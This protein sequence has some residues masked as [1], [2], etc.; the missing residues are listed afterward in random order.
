MKLFSGTSNLPL[1]QKVAEKLGVSLSDVEIKRFPDGECKVWVPAKQDSLANE[2]IFVIQ[3]LSYIADQNLMEL[4]LFGDA[5]KRLGAKK[6]TA[7]VPWMGYSKQDKEFRKGE[8][9]SAQLVAKFIE[10]AGFTGVITF[11]LHSPKIKEYFSIPLVELST[12][13]LYQEEIDGCPS[14]IIVSPDKGGRNR[15]DNLAEILNLPVAHLDKT[16]DLAG[17]AVS[18]QGIDKDISGETVIIFDDII[19]TGSTAIATAGFL[20]EKGAKQIFFFATHG[21]FSGQATKNIQ[22]SPIDKV[23]VT[24][25]IYI[26]PEKVFPKLKIISVAD[27]IAEEIQNLKFKIPQ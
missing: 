17:G 13:N 23:V 11:D 18:I 5:L 7:V 4:C 16:R 27:L 6:I 22:N 25:T 19:N 26:P 15:S 8:A 12:K 14:C 1:A 24:D 3:S 20:H 2:D 21:V 9:V 10:T